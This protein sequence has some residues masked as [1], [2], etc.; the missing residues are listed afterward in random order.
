MNES[1]DDFITKLVTTE[2]YKTAEECLR[3]MILIAREREYRSILSLAQCACS[4]LQTIGIFCNI[5][6]QDRIEKKGE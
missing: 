1:T 2:R 4:A 3:D 6:G 5:N